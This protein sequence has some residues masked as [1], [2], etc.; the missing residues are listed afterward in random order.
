MDKLAL[1]ILLE[2]KKAEKS[3]GL[4][5]MIE[6]FKGMPA[7]LLILKIPVS[8]SKEMEILQRTT[9]ELWKN[10]NICLF[11]NIMYKELKDIIDKKYALELF[12]RPN[13]FITL[14]FSLLKKTSI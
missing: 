13:Q 12:D 1:K 8:T 6:N 3:K 4:K 14:S 9:K 5:K 2:I 11:K 7:Q 10:G